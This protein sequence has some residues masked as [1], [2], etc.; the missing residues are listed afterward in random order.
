MYYRF[1]GLKSPP[2][3]KNQILCQFLTSNREQMCSKDWVR[4]SDRCYYVS[5]F[6]TTF[7]TAMQECSKRDSRLLEINS[8][9]EAS[10]V[11]Q[12]VLYKTR[13]YW[14]GKCEVGNVGWSLL[15]MTSSGTPVCTQCGRSFR[16]DGDW[17]FI[18]EKSTPLVPDVSEKIQDL[19][20]QPLEGT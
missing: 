6:E 18:C 11:S 9:D 7:H 3:K 5:T 16:C 1:V 2:N 20:Q 12:R 15:Y 4:I 13:S 8:T 14:I 19:C 10:F 17:S